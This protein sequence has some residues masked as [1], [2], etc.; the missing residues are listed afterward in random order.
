MPTRVSPAQIACL[1]FNLQK[2]KMQIGVQLLVHIEKLLKAGAKVVLT[3]KGIKDEGLRH[4]SK[5]TGATAVFMFADMEGEE[6]FDPSLHGFADEVGE[7]HISEMIPRAISLYHHSSEVQMT[8]S[9]T[10][11]KEPLHDAL[12]I[13]KRTLESNVVVASG[14]AVESALSVY[15][16]YLA[17]T[18]GSREQWAVAEFAEALLIIPKGTTRNNLE[19]GI[20]EPAMTAITILQIDDMIKLVKDDQGED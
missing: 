4:V 20:I 14:G 19:A 6:T 3:T 12:C 10:R 13:V 8:T 7:Q 2:T 9:S 11:W 16:E 17:T 18:M 5:A 1:H 15:L